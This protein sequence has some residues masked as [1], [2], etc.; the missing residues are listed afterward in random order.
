MW[1]P[2]PPPDSIMCSMRKI[3]GILSPSGAPAVIVA[4]QAAS[5]GSMLM[6]PENDV[7]LSAR[8]IWLPAVLVVYLAA[9][10][11]GAMGGIISTAGNDA[12]L[13]QKLAETVVA[14]KV[15]GSYAV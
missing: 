11:S 4:R 5:G 15:E 12:Q 8:V 13:I 6:K 10:V 3:A 7:S 14:S 1:R 2:D 9:L